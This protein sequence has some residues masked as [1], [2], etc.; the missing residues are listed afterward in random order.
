MKQIPKL[1]HESKSLTK[2][3][4]LNIFIGLV[5][6][7]IF[8]T[9]FYLSSAFGVETSLYIG[10]AGAVFST[11]A[12]YHFEHEEYMHS[13][14]RNSLK[15][16]DLDQLIQLSNSQELND[17]ERGLVVKYLNEKHSGWSISKGKP[18]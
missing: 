7:F 10:I 14:Y 18:V 13:S 8:S 9:V 3:H 16:Y 4:K 5:V 1:S 17:T 2:N 15:N 12:M 11:F 6:G